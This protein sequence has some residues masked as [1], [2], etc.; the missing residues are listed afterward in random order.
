[1]LFQINRIHIFLKRVRIPPGRFYKSCEILIE[2]II[3]YSHVPRLTLSTSQIQ[4]VY[5][6]WTKN[7]FLIILNRSSKCLLCQHFDIVL[8]TSKD[9]PQ[10]LKQTQ[11]YLHLS[12]LTISIRK[13]FRFNFCRRI[14]KPH[15]RLSLACFG[16]KKELNNPVYRFWKV[17]R[18]KAPES[19]VR[20]ETLELK[21]QNAKMSCSLQNLRSTDL[22]ISFW[23]RCLRCSFK[24]NLPRSCLKL[25][26]WW[27]SN[28][29][30]LRD[31]LSDY[32]QP[33][34]IVRGRVARQ[35]SAHQGYLVS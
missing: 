12:R 34:N 4:T 21:K 2:E 5:F 19:H 16:G 33:K 22:T 31:V 15:L 27:T 29:L 11:V 7:Y 35:V 8:N 30:K 14:R 10:V 6:F 32:K 23:A 9:E 17:T 20:L 26:D 28:I 13:K 25:A 24:L 3:V 18:N 1:M